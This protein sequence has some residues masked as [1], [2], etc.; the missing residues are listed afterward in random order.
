MI[1]QKFTDRSD[2]CLQKYF[3]PDM[4]GR[5]IS[6]GRDLAHFTDYDRKR[7]SYDGPLAMAAQLRYHE[8]KW[9]GF[10]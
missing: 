10:F 9:E 8:F 2:D 3:A 4:M 7:A 1:F 6:H 5:R